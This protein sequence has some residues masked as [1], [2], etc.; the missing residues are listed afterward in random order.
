MIRPNPEQFDLLD[1]IGAIG[2]IEA[3]EA[4]SWM[5]GDRFEKT[6]RKVRPL[7]PVGSSRGR[8][9]SSH[10]TVAS[11]KARKRVSRESSGIHLRRHRKFQ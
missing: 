1:S 10:K 8:A 4:S 6:H 7:L 11:E 5:E 9:R 3:A 2:G